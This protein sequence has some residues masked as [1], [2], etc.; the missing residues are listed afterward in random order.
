MSTSC[1][2]AIRRTSGD[3]FWRR[4]SSLDGVPRLAGRRR[5][6]GRPAIH[7]PWPDRTPAPFSTGPVSGCPT[8]DCGQALLRSRGSRVATRRW[9]R[10]G[11]SR[12]ADRGDD[13]VDRNRLPFLD[14][15]LGQH[16]CR[17]RGDLGVHLVGGDLEQRLVAIDRIADL[18]DP[19]DDRAFGD[20]LPHLGHHDVCSHELCS[21][22]DTMSDGWFD[23]ERSDSRAR[24]AQ[25]WIAAP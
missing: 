17:R 23:T 14:L 1:S 16:A 25:A 10:R 19:A 7:W 3:D 2:L 13:A 22:V 18:L 9:L 11:F 24:P 12:R 20:R 15:D 4:S 6:G 8:A 5:R 21:I